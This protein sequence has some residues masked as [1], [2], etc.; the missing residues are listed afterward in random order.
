[1]RWSHPCAD[2]LLMATPRWIAAWT[3]AA[4]VTA[5]LIAGLLRREAPVPS[6]APSAASLVSAAAP[7][8]PRCPHAIPQGDSLDTAWSTTVFFVTDVLMRKNPVCGYDLSS[9]QLRGALSRAQWA[10]GDGPVETFVTRFPAVS[11]RDASDDPAAPEA[12]YALSRT[13]REMVTSDGSGRVI[14]PLKVGLFAPDAG[15]AAYNV[16]LVL[17]NGQWRV[18]KATAVNLKISE[19][20]Y[21]AEPGANSP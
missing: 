21:L 11:V 7:G 18:D 13:V 6:P 17:E 16:E 4:V 14:A 15:M 5:G 10:N 2:D 8:A 19:Q 20:P 3:L 12:V 1:M 9:R